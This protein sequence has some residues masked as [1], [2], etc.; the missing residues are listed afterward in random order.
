MKYER[1]DLVFVMHT[2]NVISK[3]IAWFM[4]SRWSHSAVV[5]APTLLKT[6]LCETSD[7]NVCIGTLER[8]LTDEKTTR[9]VW[10][11]VDR[12]DWQTMDVMVL[13][14][15]EA[16]G[17]IYGYLQLFSFGLRRML[18]RIGIKIPN[19]IRQGMV[20]CAVPMRAYTKSKIP[21]L[22]GIDPES[23]D[24]E[25]FYTMIKTSGHFVLIDSKT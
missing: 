6:Y 4:K 13:N 1:G 12:I 17:T 5:V 3:I 10:R 20:C 23:I 21:G 7:F 19:F 8:Y 22:E 11:P 16:E 25:E 9:E 15:I 2:D 14:A 18:M 24:T